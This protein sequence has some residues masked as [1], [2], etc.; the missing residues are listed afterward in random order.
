[1]PCQQQVFRAEGLR[2][3]YRGV[4]PTTQRAA[5]LTATQVP[6]YDHTKHTLLN[7]GLFEEGL[8]LHAVSSMIAG[9]TTAL[10]TSPIDLVKTRM[11][12]QP[13]DEAG[14]GLVSLAAA[15]SW[16]VVV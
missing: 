3:L 9:V 8:A 5:M 2:G 13:L 12:N 15:L 16:Q 11:M 4:G 1:M 10:V 14:R 6:S 7:A